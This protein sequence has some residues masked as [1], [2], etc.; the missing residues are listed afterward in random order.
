MRCSPR[1]LHE[2]I[3]KHN[4]S[5]EDMIPEEERPGKLRKRDPELKPST[6][7]VIKRRRHVNVFKVDKL[8]VFKYFFEDKEAFKAFLG[9]YNKDMYRF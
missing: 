4:T 3:I 5:K 1:I 8:W 9:W 7:D 2:F 6:F